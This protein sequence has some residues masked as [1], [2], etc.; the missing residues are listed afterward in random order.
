MRDLSAG[1]RRQRGRADRTCVLRV[2][3]E[4]DGARA[5]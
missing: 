1:R 3:R 2:H 5:G 4:T